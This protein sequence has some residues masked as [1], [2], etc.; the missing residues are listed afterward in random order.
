MEMSE[1]LNGL[2][3]LLV[4]GGGFLSRVPSI[5]LRWEL[6]VIVTLSV[7]ASVVLVRI[8]VIRAGARP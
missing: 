6:G 4:V 3:R 1:L 8:G 7:A 2:T 5:G